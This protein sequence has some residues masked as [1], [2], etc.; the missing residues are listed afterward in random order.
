MVY[1]RVEVAE[2]WRPLKQARQPLHVLYDSTAAP[3]TVNLSFPTLL[4]I[5]HMVSAPS[6]SEIP[7]TVPYQACPAKS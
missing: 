5:G 4:R 3:L 7:E 6:C 1:F 2:E